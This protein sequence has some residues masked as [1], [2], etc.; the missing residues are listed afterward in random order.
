[1]DPFSGLADKTTL[2]NPAAFYPILGLRAF[3]ASFV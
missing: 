2:L 1:M 3:P